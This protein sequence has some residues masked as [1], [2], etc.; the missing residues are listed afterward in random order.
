MRAYR[1]VATVKMRILTF[2]RSKE[3]VFF[4]FFFPIML[5]VLFGYI[6]SSQGDTVYSVLVQDQDGSDLSRN[7]TKM[8]DDLKYIEVKKVPLDQDPGQYMK[9]H[10]ENFMIVIPSGYGAS[11][12]ARMT[13]DPNSTVNLTLMYDPSQTSASTKLQMTQ[14]IVQEVNKGLAGAKDT[15][16]TQAK[17]I[18]TR[19][20]KFIEFFIPGVI[21]MTVMTSAVFGTIYDNN[22][23]KQKGIARKLYTT[24]ITR[25]EWVLSNM[26]YQ[27]LVA[28]IY[29]VLILFVGWA[30][31][32]AWLDLNIFLPLVVVAG[33]LAFSGLG[34]L[35]GRAVKDSQSAS[36]LGNLITFPMMFL[37]GSFFPLE[38]MP[39]FLRTLAQIFPL[40]YVNESLRE[41]MIFQNFG[42][43]SVYFAVIMAFAAVVFALGILVTK[44]KQD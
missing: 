34:M 44:W 5:M 36:A 23:F 33:A 11:V 4:T 17:S 42:E 39:G 28:A 43:A 3:A 32:G 37:S 21:G 24:P 9:E 19:S 38:M 31:F 30:L 12:L 8:L 15:I 6:F 1:V 40:Y 10:N 18:T 22:E 7:L 16:R 13:G 26:L 2:Y 41:A 25:G 20:Y 14:A 35:V 29:T 27:L